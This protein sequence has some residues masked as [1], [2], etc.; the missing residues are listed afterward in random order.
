MSGGV[1]DV[2]SDRD[3]GLLIPPEDPE[4]L[5]AAVAELAADPAASALMALRGRRRVDE[6][7]SVGR[8]GPSARVRA[9]GDC[10]TRTSDASIRTSRLTWT[11]T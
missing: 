3:T 2:V 5:A 7:F 11:S 4:R 6:R 8:H 10:S 9:A 1:G